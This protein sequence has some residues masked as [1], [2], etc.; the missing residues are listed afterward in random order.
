[1]TVVGM[2][3]TRTQYADMKIDLELYVSVDEVHEWRVL[4]SEDL[5]ERIT[6]ALTREF[7]APRRRER[8]RLL[9]ERE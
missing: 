8:H 3:I 5:S 7:P 1:M 6:R 4:N 2:T 9:I